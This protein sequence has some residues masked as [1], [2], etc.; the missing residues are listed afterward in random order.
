MWSNKNKTDSQIVN[1]VDKVDEPEQPKKQELRQAVKRYVPIAGNFE[2]CYVQPIPLPGHIEI[3]QKL[4]A[5]GLDLVKIPIDE[6]TDM[7]Y[8]RD[9][10][11]RLLKQCNLQWDYIEEVIKAYQADDKTDEDRKAL[12]NI[13]NVARD[14]CKRRN[15]EFLTETL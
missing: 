7:L 1:D 15:I 13:V 5:T 6:K 14:F 3:L 9:N 8:I 11:N 10:I 12:I 2:V 4:R